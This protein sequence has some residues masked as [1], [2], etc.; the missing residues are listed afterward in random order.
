MLIVC[1]VIVL[2]GEVVNVFLIFLNLVC[3]KQ[4]SATEDLTVM[5]TPNGNDFQSR[6]AN[7]R[8][9]VVGSFIHLEG[10]SPSGAIFTRST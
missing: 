8:T 2:F 10:D 1:A 4:D 7:L 5:T 3:A 6:W 9:I